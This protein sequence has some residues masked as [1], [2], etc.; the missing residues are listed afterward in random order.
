MSKSYTVHIS[1]NKVLKALTIYMGSI[2]GGGT[3]GHVPP[4]FWRV[5]DTISINVPPPFWPPLSWSLSFAL[6]KT[7]PCVAPCTLILGE[8]GWHNFLKGGG[9]YIKCPPSKL[10]LYC[11]TEHLKCKIFPGPWSGPHSCRKGFSHACS[12]V[13]RFAPPPWK[14]GRDVYPHPIFEGW[15]IQYQ[16]FP[17]SFDP[18]YHDSQVLHYM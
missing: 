18:H 4:T 12:I 17:L 11:T 6:C 15:G 14:S 1:T 10:S 3:G 16:M 7:K 13:D 9:H 2:R 5:G 8:K